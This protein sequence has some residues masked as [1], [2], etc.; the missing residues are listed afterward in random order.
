MESEKT[1]GEDTDIG[2]RSW[3]GQDILP[4][5]HV[6][7]V[8]GSLLK[9]LARVQSGGAWALSE[10]PLPPE[11]CPKALPSSPLLGDDFTVPL[12]VPTP[13]PH[14]ETKNSHHVSLDYLPILRAPLVILKRGIVQPRDLSTWPLGVGPPGSLP[15]PGG[16]MMRQRGQ[17]SVPWPCA[18]PPDVA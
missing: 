5:S 15:G 18:S 7:V 12:L 17:V 8:L 6:L 1:H 16:P 2:A 3:A 4:L 14:W 13:Y 10:S 9:D 11:E